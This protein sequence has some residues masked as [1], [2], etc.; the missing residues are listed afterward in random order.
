[1][2]LYIDHLF[3]RGLLD[4]ML[5]EG[6]IRAQQHPDDPYLTIYNYTD[7]AQIEGVWNPAT[8]ACRGLIIRYEKDGGSLQGRVV[9]RPFDKF[10]NLS[11]QPNAIRYD[12]PVRAY[13]KM[14][15][16]LGILYM[17]PD[18]LPAIATRGSF[19]SPQAQHATE[20]YRERYH[21]KW[22]PSVDT[23]TYL[24]EI[25]Y[26][27]NRIVLNYGDRD[28]LVLLGS[29]AILSGDILDP[30]T[31]QD[32]DG[33]PGPMSEVLYEGPMS[34]ALALEDRP[35]AEGVV[36]RYGDST[37]V[38]VKQADYVALHKIVFGLNERAVWEHLSSGKGINEMLD[39]LPDEFHS[40]VRGVALDLL[41][42]FNRIQHQC[43]EDLMRCQQMVR[44][45]PLF[46]LPLVDP[47]RE[48]RAYRKEIADYI[49]QCEHSGIVFSMLDGKD[50]SKA[51]WK[52]LYP[53]HRTFADQPEEALA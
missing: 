8:L 44:T 31:A 11:E 45:Q 42:R 49:R 53:P 47:E 51:I 29:R 36:L 4:Q 43:A 5:H 16:S 40:W 41:L 48:P 33:W 39:G 50:P 3:D 32:F 20:V 46:G 27:E 17:A 35:N 9:A 1:M 25:I 24:F 6:Y 10:F 52:L 30:W 26:P 37:Q 22:E 15:G 38:K 28:D 18:G 13:D 7:K 2:N 12:L 21:G 14:D 19:S 23:E 34:G